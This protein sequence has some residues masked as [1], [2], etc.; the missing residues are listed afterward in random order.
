[1]QGVDEQSDELDDWFRARRG[2]GE[3]F[4]RIFDRHRDRVFRHSLRLVDTPADADDVVATVFLEAWRRRDDVRIVADSVLPWLLVTATHASRNVRRSTRRY[5]VLLDRLPPDPHIDDPALGLEEGPAEAALR[6][7]PLADRQVLTLC[8]L[9]DLP[10]AD[11][12]HVLGVAIG[13][14]KSRL[15]RARARLARLLLA[16]DTRAAT[17]PIPTGGPIHES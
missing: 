15:S 11:A 6:R 1:V 9:L 5:R 8:V 2:E 17:E 13:T 12:A 10:D 7:L 4:G 16:D 3:A 14:V